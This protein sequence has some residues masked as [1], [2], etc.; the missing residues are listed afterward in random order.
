MLSRNTARKEFLKIGNGFPNSLIAP[1]I[2]WRDLKNRSRSFHDNK[3]FTSF[4]AG[5]VRIRVFPQI[6]ESHDGSI[7]ITEDYLK[8]IL[9]S[10]IIVCY[11][12]TTHE[13]V[14]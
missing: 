14:S 11:N 2:Y 7:H 12:H 6:F 8:I 13:D 9:V 5:D 1:L 4:D 3:R 10:S